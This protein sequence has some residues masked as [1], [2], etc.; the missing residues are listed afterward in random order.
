MVMMMPVPVPV[1]DVAVVAVNRCDQTIVEMRGARLAFE[2][3]GGVANGEVVRQHSLNA[4]AH[5]LS[6]FERWMTI[7]HHVRGQRSHRARQTPDV[8][9]VQTLDTI[10]SP[11]SAA[12]CLN[13]K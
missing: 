8:Q 3:E 1:V 13:I 9:I 6:F 2:F 11:N 5:T 12:H 7:E 4:L 10:D